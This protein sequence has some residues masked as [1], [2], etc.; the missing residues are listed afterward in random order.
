MENIDIK[1]WNVNQ[2]NVTFYLWLK[3]I[4]PSQVWIYFNC[5]TDLVTY[6]LIPPIRGPTTYLQNFEWI[7][8]VF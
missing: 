6:W 2:V 7:N 5:H 1:E 8:T 3:L 4:A